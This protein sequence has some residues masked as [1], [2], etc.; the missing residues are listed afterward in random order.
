MVDHE[1]TG[2]FGEHYE[3]KREFFKQQEDAS[4]AGVSGSILIDHARRW[5]SNPA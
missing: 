3:S 4:I 1:C 5:V 2:R